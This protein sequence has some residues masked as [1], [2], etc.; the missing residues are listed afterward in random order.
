MQKNEITTLN[1]LGKISSVFVKRSKIVI[2]LLLMT[3]LMGYNAITTMT[4]EFMPKVTIPTLTIS[5]IYPGATAEEVESLVTDKIEKEM[6]HIKDLKKIKSES[7]LNFSLVT[8][9]FETGIDIKEK[10][11]DVREKL[12]TVIN[13]LPVEAERPI[14]SYFDTDAV[15]LMI[16][17]V[18][19]NYDEVK[20]RKIT[21]DIKDDLEDKIE[22]LGPIQ[23]SGGREREIQVIINPYHLLHYNSSVDEIAQS[24]KRSNLNYPSGSTTLSGQK[25][26]II[27][28]GKVKSVSDI[29][30]IVVRNTKGSIITISDLA[31]VKDG[32]KEIS[33]YS[34]VCVI[35]ENEAVKNALSLSIIK[36]KSADIFHVS[37]QVYQVVQDGKGS[38]YPEDITISI[39]GDNANMI[40]K[41]LTDVTDNAFSGLILVV[42]VMYLLLGF[43]ESLIVSTVIPFTI[44]IAMVLM[45]SFGMSI[46]SMTLFSLVLAIGLLVDNA[47]VIMENIV[48]VH[49][50]GYTP[51]SAAINATNQI[52]PAVASSTL[53]TLAAFFPMMLT[54]GLIGQFM[55]SLPLTVIFSL[56]ASLLVALIL[57]PNASRFVLSMKFTKKIK[58]KNF[59]TIKNTAIVLMVL[60][61]TMTAFKS[62]TGFG[63]YS[64]VFGLIFS[65]I[66]YVKLFKSSGETLEKIIYVYL[67][68][69]SSV[70]SSKKRRLQLITVFVIVFIGAMSM[71]PLGLVKL[72]Y[73]ETIDVGKFYVDIETPNGSLL[74]DTLK[75]ATAVE[76]ELNHIKEVKSY[77]TTVGNLGQDSM[78]FYA[79][80]SGSHPSIARIQVDLIDKSHRDKSSQVI[81]KE[82]KEKVKTIPGGDIYVNEYKDLPTESAPITI[83]VVG[84]DLKQMQKT[85]DY[86]YQVIS[87]TK[88]TT[89][90]KRGYKMSAPEISV[91]LNQLKASEYGLSTYE[92][93][94]FL[95]SL[96]SGVEV[97]K[98]KMDGDELDIRMKI[99]KQNTSN[100][101]ALKFVKIQTMN[102]GAIPLEEIAFFNEAVSFQSISHESRD[103][104]INVTAEI[105]LGYNTLDVTKEIQ[106]KIDNNRIPG[107][108]RLK[109]SGESEEM[110]KSF[111]SMGINMLVAVIVIYIILSVQFNSLLQPIFI[112]LTVPMSLI[113]VFIG[114][115]ITGNS[116]GFMSF[117]GIVALVGIAVN[118]A[119]VLIDTINYYRANGLP[120]HEAVINAGKSRFIP[121]IATTVTTAG[122]ILPLTLRQD[123]YEAMGYSIAFGLC[124]AT[125][126]TLILVPVV[127]TSFEEKLIKPEKEVVK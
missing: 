63:I 48:K 106:Q 51:E 82:F 92:V 102:Y 5:T 105:E 55:K 67:T 62:E 89:N 1:A 22:G 58:S 34:R 107:N 29:E 35:G 49:G 77:T 122:G 74:E 37:Q 94:T 73:L 103:R 78:N 43:K 126:L 16:L 39:S 19:G 25:R 93:A 24:I 10:Q 17:N 30:K 27:T 75:V 57:T 23:L 64:I 33:T 114:L 8:L 113:G 119:I 21:E 83:G 59:I 81:V 14:T 41:Q 4:R 88:G 9:E 79:T 3:L 91:R 6:E 121:V 110:N 47:I 104:I 2:L 44:M 26:N 98:T 61:A 118:G 38:V 76:E 12:N 20:L 31:Q 46:N 70:I 95:R 90:P 13:D 32:L 15:P 50:E 71:I 108:I 11:N 120:L 125:M 100:I 53:T 66:A 109:Y 84:E 69:L 115:F 40:N 99:E 36:K 42:L 101:E 116:F 112:L 54:P 85:A 97:S 80:E 7:Q 127:Y 56:I 117:L 123:F 86:V 96:I 87:D 124:F 18:S 72:N 68:F 60:I 45:K 52:A 65:V 111:Q 28:K